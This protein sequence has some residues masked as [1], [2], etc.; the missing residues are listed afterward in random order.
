MDT[1]RVVGVILWWAEGSKSRRDKRWA[2]A[3]SYPI[4]VTN[5]NPAIIRVFIRYITEVVGIPRENLKVQI[6]IHEN[7][8]K[9]ELE[10]YWREVTGIPAKSFNKTIVRKIGN[11]PNKTKGTCKVR[12]YS[13][14]FYGRIQD[15]LQEVLGHIA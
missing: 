7:D 1:L 2:H 9:N 12:C 14:E 6:Q 15:D 8:S 3:V 4:E 13:K 5:T 10:R 11:K